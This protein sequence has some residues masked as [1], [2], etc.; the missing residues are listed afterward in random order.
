MLWLTAAAMW[1]GARLFRTRPTSF[2]PSFWVNALVT[3]LILLGPGI[4]DAAVG[5]DVYLA[6]AVRVALYIALSFYA[7]AMVW[8]FER[9]F[10]SSPAP[11]PAPRP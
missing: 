4:E 3:M 8:A 11:A 10:T 5:K 9:W 6:S 1:A 7:W 2:P